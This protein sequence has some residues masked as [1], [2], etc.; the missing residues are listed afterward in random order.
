MVLQNLDDCIS[1]NSSK[2]EYGCFGNMAG[3]FPLSFLIRGDVITLHG[4]EVFYQCLK[5]TE[6]PE[7]QEILVAEKN[8]L[9]CKWKQ[10]PF[11]K[12]GLVRSDWEDIKVPAMLFSLYLKIISHSIFWVKLKGTGDRLIVEISK[13]DNFWGVKPQKDGTYEGENKLGECLMY[14]R[15]YFNNY[16]NKSDNLLLNHPVL[17]GLTLLGEPIRIIY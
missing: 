5:Y 12:Q 15:E 6:H 7:I 3:G 2:D 11:A 14:I 8:P 10:K 9:K 17:Q 4:S 13:K 1:F 16:D